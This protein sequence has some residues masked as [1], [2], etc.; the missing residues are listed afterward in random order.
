MDTTFSLFSYLFSQ[1]L[2]F[3]ILT[4]AFVLLLVWSIN[5]LYSRKTIVVLSLIFLGWIFIG[6]LPLSN[7]DLRSYP[8]SMTT[9]GPGTG[10]VL[11]FGNMLNFFTHVD[12]LEKVD[13]IARDPN[14]VPPPIDREEPAVVD[15][16][17]TTKE[18][19]AEVAPGVFL[20]YWTFDGQVPGPMLRVREGDTV[21][22]TLKNDPS[23]L[24]HHNIDLHAVTGPGGGASVTHVA[25]GE[26]KTLTF[27]A[28][29]PG[30]FVYHCAYPNMANHMAHGMYGL[31]LVEP[32]EGLSKVDREFYVMQGESY[33]KG[34]LGS[35]G[36][37]VFDSKAMLDG[38]PTYIVFN[39][40]VGGTVGNMT[41]EV[42]ETVRMFIG[43][44][45]VNLISSIHMVGEIFDRVNPEG[46]IGN[47]PHR[48]VSTTLVP[49]GGASIVEFGLEMPGTYVLVDHALAR[50]DRGAWG[51]L[52]VI[53]SASSTIYD[54]DFTSPSSHGH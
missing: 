3:V 6:V 53:G 35:R 30:L 42:G 8:F 27:K 25:P 40:K 45:G 50:A 13:N 14:E 39:G 41:G 4:I 7:I 31:I 49:A 52:T 11:P 22:L 37:Q 33:S 34:G 17:L 9:Y 26:S 20:N 24:H 2:G 12:E 46:A 43:N 18:V 44:G 1:G 51:T 15:I 54:G 36:L 23:S 21:R 38:Q 47:D 32:A 5:D 28:L 29:N 16:T 48:N 10:P 19:V